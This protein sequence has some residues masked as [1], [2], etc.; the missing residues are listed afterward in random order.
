MCGVAAAYAYRGDAAAV[1]RDEL[2]AV[3]DHMAARGPDGQGEW[4]S[5]DGRVGLGHRR[6]AIIDLS[7][8]AAQPMASADGRLVISYNGE[9]YNYR[10]LKAQLRQAGHV[11]HSDSDTEVILHL[12]EVHGTAM[13]GMLRGM[14]AFSLWDSRRREMLLAR[15]AFGM[16]PMYYANDGRTLR[17]ASQVKAL[18]RAAVDTRPEPAGHAGFFLWGSVPAPFT[19]YRGIRALPAGHFMRIGDDGA[20][21]PTSFCNVAERIARASN[22]PARGTR[23]DA[24]EALGAALRST[25]AAH[26]VSDVPVGVFLSGGLDSTVLAAL[27]RERGGDLRTLTLG[28]PEYEGTHDDEMPHAALVSRLLATNHVALSVHKSD[29]LECKA[30]LLVQM[31]QP[32]IDGVNTWLV[33]RAAASAGIKVALSGLG[34]DE[35]FASYPSFRDVPRLARWLRPWAHAPR[36]GA[37]VRVLS[38]PLVRSFTSPKFAGLL[39]YGGT[40]GGAY[41]LRRGLHMPWELPRLMDPDMARAGWESLQTMARLDATTRGIAGDRLAVSALETCWYMRHQ[42]LADADWAG[43]AHSVE[44]RVPFV[45]LPLLEEAARWFAAYPELAKQDVVRAAAPQ[46]PATLLQ[47]PKT[48][49]NV[50]VRQWLGAHGPSTRGLRGWSH[51]VHASH[52]TT[53]PRRAARRVLVSTLAPANGGVN[54]M[55]QFAVQTL[56]QSGF[57]PVL[58]YYPTYS[59]LPRMSV[60]SFRLLQRRPAHKVTYDAHGNEMHAIGAWLPEL[61]FTH[62]LPTRPWR[63]LMESCE[64]HMAV[65]GNALAATPFALAGKPFLGWIA[66]DWDG[67]RRDRVRA[68]PWPRRLLDACVNGPVIRVLERR[69]LRAGRIVSLS[70]YT[71]R[72][73]QQRAHAAL[74]AM[75]VPVPVDTELFSPQPQ[76]RI[77]GRLGFAG[78]F[79]DPR[80]NIHLLLQAA[81][82]LRQQGNDV[83]VVLLG[84]APNESLRAYVKQIGMEPHVAFLGN[85]GQQQMRD[86]V[87]TLDVFVLASHQEGLCISALEALS[88]AVPVVSTRCGGPEEFVLPGISGELVDAEPAAL[89]A[90]VK[91]LI[92]DPVRRVSL[93]QSAR[94]LVEDGY[95]IA[96]ARVLMREQLLAAYPVPQA[97]ATGAVATQPALE[98]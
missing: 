55:T 85:L 1:D 40:F 95:S 17:A 32:S 30:K 33:A 86:I 76:S 82:Q 94:K 65:S 23:E 75:V 45:D 4:F 49:F 67:D 77:A 87:R 97:S 63:K 56:Q 68:F 25:V 37:V 50:P 73:L 93:G 19:L 2:R 59:A 28:F 51:Q 74:P 69:L 53:S 10:E 48:G 8:R 15:D 81:A 83:H 38:E 42:L 43:M 79:N 3:R 71:A 66:T 88:C 6:L 5:T 46:L 29:F 80:K 84:D 61:E 18:L 27:A 34:G 11:F 31:D 54:A 47:R 92:D 7:P 9:I 58:A 35:I 60:P 20:E 41:L 14:F 89:A 70:A 96:R 57:E 44:M 39:E 78:R 16:K 24:I 62:Y 91:R 52:A 22:D 12:Y 64:G 21:A 13:L 36:M 72:V 98:A 90:A 26:L